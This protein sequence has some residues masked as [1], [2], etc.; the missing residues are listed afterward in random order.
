MDIEAAKAAMEN[1][2][3]DFVVRESLRWMEEHGDHEDAVVL[4]MAIVEQAIVRRVDNGKW[5]AQVGVDF[6]YECGRYMPKAVALHLGVGYRHRWRPLQWLAIGFLS[7]ML[8]R[9]FI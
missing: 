4:G 2:R 3:T 5:A 7:A 8:L 1:E 9:T 6:A